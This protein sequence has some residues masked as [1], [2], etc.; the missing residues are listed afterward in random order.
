[1]VFGLPSPPVCCPPEGDRDRPDGSMLVDL[2]PLRASRAYRAL[3]LSQSALLLGT[4]RVTAVA[5]PYQ[6]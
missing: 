1:M 4:Q 2:R 6:A 3:L 5:A